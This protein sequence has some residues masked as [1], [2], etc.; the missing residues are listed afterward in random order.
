MKIVA[1]ISIYNEE[2]IIERSLRHLFEQGIEVYIINND[3]TDSTME[4]VDKYYGRGVVG[5]ERLSR[6]GIIEQEPRTKKTEELHSI[7][8]ADWYIH[9]DADEIRESPWPGVSLHD[10]ISRVDREGYNAI[11]FDE[12]VFTPTVEE[13]DFEGTDFVEAMRYYYFFDKGRV[14]RLNA[15]KNIGQRI[16]LRGGHKVRFEEICVY[17][18]NFVMRHYM[19]LSRNHIIKKYCTDKYSDF[20]INEYGWHRKR[21]WITPELITLPSKNQL[22]RYTN[23]GKWERSRPVTEHYI[24]QNVPERPKPYSLFKRIK[25]KSKQLFKRYNS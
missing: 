16:R 18:K 22:H 8:G 2:R 14:R 12:F 9:H 10:A 3:C 4:I 19:V 24:F 6:R 15:W 23:D 25:R 21:A 5:I 7:L 13:P 1:I 20:E 11:N 17:P